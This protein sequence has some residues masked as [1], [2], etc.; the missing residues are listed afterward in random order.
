M[1][2]EILWAINPINWDF[3]SIGD[4]IQ[5]ELW[6]LLLLVFAAM[7][8]ELANIKVPILTANFAAAVVISLFFIIR[9]NG[10]GFTAFI[11][12]TIYLI[13]IVVKDR[14]VHLEAEMY[15]SPQSKRSSRRDK[16]SA[17]QT[18]IVVR[19]VMIFLSAC[20]VTISIL[21][22]N[23]LL[24]ALEQFETQPILIAVYIGLAIMIFSIISLLGC[25]A[26]YGKQ[27]KAD[28]E[29]DKKKGFI[30]TGKFKSTQS[31][32]QFYQI[33]FFFGVLVSGAVFYLGILQWFM[34]LLGFLITRKIMLSKAAELEQ[35]RRIYLTENS[36]YKKYNLTT[37]IF[38][39]IF[40]KTS[41]L[42]ELPHPSKKEVDSTDE[43]VSDTGKP[44]KK[45][46]DKKERPKRER[47]KKEKKDKKENDSEK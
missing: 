13:Y 22:F 6:L 18:P 4:A 37:A 46:P 43:K 16:K 42:K 9:Y 33:V 32:V 19:V 27:N 23:Y 38:N 44:D 25:M 31:P 34:V 14:A 1:L 39:P 24:L 41:L 17:E 30:S 5:P 8:I 36:E 12:P 45:R 29:D 20:W 28:E 11:L 21:P 3:N 2:S 40:P 15:S 47:P 10:S 35:H 26:D 7:L